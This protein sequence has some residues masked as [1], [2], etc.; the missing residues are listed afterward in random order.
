[1]R[2]L[3]ILFIDLLN[4]LVGASAVVAVDLIIYAGITYMT[5]GGDPDNVKKVGNILT[6]NY[7]TMYCIFG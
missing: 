1:M 3:L 7:W 4:F 6:A 5:A 2:V